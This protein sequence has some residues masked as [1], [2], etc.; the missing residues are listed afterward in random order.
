MEYEAKLS[1]I[2]ASLPEVSGGFLYS[3]EH[4][5]YANQTADLADTSSL[6]KVSRK[7]TAIVSMIKE[8][9]Q[10]TSGIRVSFK[11]L[12]LCGIPIETDHWLFLLHQPSLSSGM[13]KMTVRIALNIDSSIDNSEEIPSP[14]PEDIRPEDPPEEQ[15]SMMDILLAPESEL[16]IPLTEME[17]KLAHFIGPVAGLVF[18]DSVETWAKTNIPSMENIPELLNIIE[19]EIDDETDRIQFRNS[20]SAKEGK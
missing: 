13:I 2:I 16:K 18:K 1:D 3:S 11:D 19:N 15:E 9:F 5:V 4:G 10:D 12:I 20:F 17:E 14:T 6:L 7:L 8:H